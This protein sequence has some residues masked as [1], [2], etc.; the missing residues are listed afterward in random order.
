MENMDICVFNK[1]NNRCIMCT[2]PP[3]G[4]WPAWDGSFD[5]GIDALAK[6]IFKFK[7]EN[8]LKQGEIKTVYLSGGEP[9]INPDF[10]VFFGFLKEQFPTATVK[11]LTNGRTFFYQDFCKKVL[12]AN[13]H[14][15]IIFSICGPNAKVHDMVTRTPGS[16]VQMVKG[17]DNLLRLRKSS[18]RIGIRF[19]ISKLTVKYIAK[20][21]KFIALN[22][23]TLD[24]IAVIFMEIEGHGEK[25]LKLLEVSYD[26]KH[27]KKELEKNIAIF[28]KN[29]NISLYHFPLCTVPQ[30]LWPFVSRTLPMEEIDFLEKCKKCQVR[31][32]CLGIPKYYLENKKKEEVEKEIFSQ[33]LN[34]IKIIESSN[35]HKPIEKIVFQ[36]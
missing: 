19:V 15:E 28:Q 36:K 26:D 4:K 30:E 34:G 17:L 13:E 31:K 1:C 2:N 9:T 33:K 14:A 32:F 8:N 11:L 27:I 24:E 22:F 35:Y 16:F 7:Q 20:T 3:S 23:P 29:K 18:H 12:E 10:I 6:R 21:L 5:Y 25:N